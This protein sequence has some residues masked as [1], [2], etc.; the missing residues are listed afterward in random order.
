MIKDEKAKNFFDFFISNKTGDDY[1]S[2][3]HKY[4][5]GISEDVISRCVGLTLDKIREL[6]K[7]IKK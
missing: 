5:E 3:L 4:K 1:T 7:T 2:N 6:A